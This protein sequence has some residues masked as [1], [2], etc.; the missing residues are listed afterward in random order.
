MPVDFSTFSYGFDLFI[1]PLS[2]VVDK[3]E[4][5]QQK[6]YTSEQVMYS[7]QKAQ[8][9]HTVRQIHLLQVQGT[10]NPDWGP[11]TWPD[12]IVQHLRSPG[13]LTVQVYVYNLENAPAMRPAPGHIVPRQSAS[14]KT[15]A[16]H[17]TQTQLPNQSSLTHQSVS[18]EDSSSDGAEPHQQASEP[19][20]AYVHTV[21]EHLPLHTKS[22]LILSAEV[23]LDEL[24]VFHHDL[25]ALDV[26]LPPNTLVLEL[27]DGL[28]LFPSLAPDSASSDMASSADKAAASIPTLPGAAALQMQSITDHAV[29]DAGSITE[30][31]CSFKIICWSYSQS[32]PRSIIMEPLYLEAAQASCPAQS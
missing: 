2:A 4:Q 21:S 27:T 6:L 5:A 24:H 23:N 14:T 19:L 15:N 11:I 12:D 18:A 29:P 17:F 8:S 31:V 22:T 32:Q 28:G 10:C 9:K 3:C 16:S 1:T 20:Q 26:C 13:L 7:A 30:Q 25:P